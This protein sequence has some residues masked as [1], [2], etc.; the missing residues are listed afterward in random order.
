MSPYAEREVGR[1]IQPSSDWYVGAFMVGVLVFGAGFWTGIW[2]EARKPRP[3]VEKEI[4]YRTPLMQ[5]QC[6]SSERREYIEACKQRI[7]S[8]RVQGPQ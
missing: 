6:T 1:V 5:F 8:G 3:A 2:S 4:V 7:R